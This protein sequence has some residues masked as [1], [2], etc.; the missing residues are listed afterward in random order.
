MGLVFVV[1]AGVLFVGGVLAFDLIRRLTRTS[2][3]ALD[4]RVACVACG[5]IEDRWDVAPGVYQCLCGYEGG[6]GMAAWQWQQECEGLAAM[7][8]AERAA[9]QQAHAD[10]ARS[11]LDDVERAL[12]EVEPGVSRA[13]AGEGAEVET[14]LR[15]VRASLRAART[16][17]LD[18]LNSLEVA[19]HLA[20][21]TGP[22]DEDRVAV[23]M[24]VLI[25]DGLREESLEA[26]GEE[27]ARLR[28][29]AGTWRART[30]ACER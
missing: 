14:A 22:L 28:A 24:V 29:F 10:A 23:K 2:V 5:S 7:S 26:I 17:L 21:G 6:P 25:P 4:D 19:E 13:L 20:R 16:Y 9:R 30:E 11:C 18:C 3:P 1:G 8:P 15:E 27:T 12:S